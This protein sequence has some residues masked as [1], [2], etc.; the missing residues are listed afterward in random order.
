MPEHT[1][2]F[3]R[4]FKNEQ[5]L[6]VWIKKGDQFA[7]FQQY[8]ICYFSGGLGPKR[9]EGDKQ[10]PEGLY[11]IAVFNPE[12]KFHLSLR[13]NYPNE[14]D[15]M[16]SHPV[17]PGG[18]IYIHGD[19]VSTGC[20]AMTDDLMEEIYV[21]SLQSFQAGQINIPVHIFPFRFSKKDIS[22]KDISKRLYRH[23]PLW[24]SLLPVYRFF[25]EMKKIPLFTIDEKGMYQLQP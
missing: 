16:L 18:D 7:L 22:K 5:I 8:P 4:V 14:S 10:V 20:L 19:C 17:K 9:K 23:L 21:L 24:N 25:E 1:E 3:F 15:R 11:H 2:L 6:E 13:I 12:S